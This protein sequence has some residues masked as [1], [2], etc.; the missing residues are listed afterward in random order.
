[1]LLVLYLSGH[2]TLNNSV[3]VSKHSVLYI[4]IRAVKR[5]VIIV[6]KMRKSVYQR[7]SLHEVTEYL[8]L[9][10]SYSYREGASTA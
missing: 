5:F 4:K 10:S 8:V 6:L 7:D 3:A 2:G 9:G 1:M